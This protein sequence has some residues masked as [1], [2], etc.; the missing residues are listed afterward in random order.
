MKKQEMAKYVSRQYDW[1]NM[2]ELYKAYNTCSAEKWKAW[3]H[4]KELCHKYDGWGLKVLGA[5]TYQF[6][7]GFLFND[8]IGEVKI[9]KITASGHRAYDY[10]GEE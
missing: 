8:D 5:N 4:C 9:M 7:A 3:E 2:D 1:S 6:S 10:I